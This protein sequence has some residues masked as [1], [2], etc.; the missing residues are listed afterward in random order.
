MPMDIMNHQDGDKVV[1]IFLTYII[2]QFSLVCKTLC[3]EYFL[4]PTWENIDMDPSVVLE[5][6]TWFADVA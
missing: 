3:K 1:N 6:E 4:E 5:S 2:T